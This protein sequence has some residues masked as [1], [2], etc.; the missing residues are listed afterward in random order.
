MLFKIVLLIVAL[1]PVYLFARAI[2]FRRSTRLAEEMKTFR[3]N[4]DRAIWVL[5]AF[6]G[7]M[8]AF[9]AAKLAWT[10]WIAA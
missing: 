5:L 6:I 3:K 10:W 9:G 8:I 4:F 1:V 7:C 2:L